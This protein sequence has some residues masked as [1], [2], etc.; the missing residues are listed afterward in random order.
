M[1]FRTEFFAAAALAL[2]LSGPS[3]AADKANATGAPRSLHKPAAEQQK[4]PEEGESQ[5]Q[6]SQA[7]PRPITP[8]ETLTNP[9]PGQEPADTR[10]WES[11]ELRLIPSQAG[12]R[13]GPSVQ[14]GALGGVDSSVVGLSEDGVMPNDMWKGTSRDTVDNLLP[15]L[16]V[17]TTSPAMNAL[18]RRL[19]ISAAA[20]PQTG[21][22]SGPA[23]ID[24]RLERLMAGG[25]VE[26]IAQL[27]PL[28]HE[29]S[30]QARRIWVD[31]LLFLG[32]DEDACKD[33]SA[34]RL[35]SAD[36]YWLKIRAYCYIVEG[37]MPGASLTS[38]LM[39]TQG[40]DDESFYA[41]VGHLAESMP[42]KIGS[43]LDPSPVGLA[44]FRRAEL[45]VPEDVIRG[46]GPAEMRSIALLHSKSVDVQLAAAEGAALVGAFAPRDLAAIYENV[47]FKAKQFDNVQKTA[48][49]LSVSRANAL[50]YQAAK[51][52]KTNDDKAKAVASALEFAKS[53]DAFPFYAR[54]FYPAIEEV[55][56]SPELA[57]YAPEFGRALMIALRYDRVQDWYAVLDYKSTGTSEAVNALQVR[58]AIA[59]PSD[60]QSQR[61]ASAVEWLVRESEKRPQGD[62][63]HRRAAL[64]VGLLD[65]LGY[66]IPPEVRAK[67]LQ[68]PLGGTGFMPATTVIEG[69]NS[70]AGAHRVGETALFALAAMG[71]QGPASAHP[72]AIAQAVAALNEV[73]LSED[74]RAIALEALL[75]RPFVSGV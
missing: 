30:D 2:V 15:R 26:E 73:G 52:A 54:M 31:A 11:K 64:E 36:E 6:P 67:L 32:R 27:A 16:P 69:L 34:P 44:M 61:A 62:P 9:Q 37:N 28:M 72:E 57:P 38:E 8:S 46:A 14:V 70:A 75:A 17:A 74:A 39:R 19:L 47:E 50:F 21:A 63:I 45:A 48:P 25:H 18:A 33:A 13:S 51:R 58:L 43:Y 71:T 41:L 1:R 49:T 12:T 4:T 55:L 53:Q 10:A 24:M 7:Q 59:L 56:P 65:A 40:I 66:P 3:W 5:D 23:I 29:P 68:G 60:F 42:A 22:A 20:S 35:E